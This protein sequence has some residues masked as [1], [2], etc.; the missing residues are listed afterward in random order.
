MDTQAKGRYWDKSGQCAVERT[1][2][3]KWG[4]E[5]LNASHGLTA[6]TLPGFTGPPPRLRVQSRSRTQLRI[7]ASI[8][9]LSRTGFEGVFRHY[10]TTITRL[11]PVSGLQGGVQ[12]SHLRLD[13]R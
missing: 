8:G 11:S 6:Q 4:F 1:N 2:C 9:F 12:D 3:G 7:A 10:S 5:L 13:A